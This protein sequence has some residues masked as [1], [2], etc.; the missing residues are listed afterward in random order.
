M[1]TS[2]ANHTPPRHPTPPPNISQSPSTREVSTKQKSVVWNTQNERS[3][4]V[5]VLQDY[6]TKI[7]TNLPTAAAVDLSVDDNDTT[8]TPDPTFAQEWNKFTNEFNNFY[9]DFVLFYNEYAPSHTAILSTETDVSHLDRSFNDDDNGSANDRK[10]LAQQHQVFEEFDM[11]NHQLS[12]LLDQL[13]NDPQSPFHQCLTRFFTPNMPPTLDPSNP[14]QTAPLPEPQIVQPPKSIPTGLVPPA[15]DPAPTREPGNLSTGQSTLTTIPNTTK[16]VVCDCIP[17]QLLP[18][19]PDPDASMVYDGTSLWPPP[20]PAVKTTPF[21]K[22]SLT[23]YT[24]AKHTRG[25]DF[26]RLP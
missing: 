10:P 22:K 18:P 24:I 12:Q 23:K 8:T 4:K 17:M 15:P 2:M 11:V 26:L 25:K 21:K 9:A 6:P 5:N 1:T 19:A 16:M 13:E 7:S 14:P 3:D 20:Q